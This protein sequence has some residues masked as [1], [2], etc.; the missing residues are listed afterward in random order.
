MPEKYTKRTYKHRKH[1]E[2]P[3]PEP[4]GEITRVR[5]DEQRPL[6]VPYRLFVENLYFVTKDGLLDSVH[7]KA[8]SWVINKISA[9]EEFDMELTDE[10]ALRLRVE[11]KCPHRL[12]TIDIVNMYLDCGATN[13]LFV[14]SDE[15]E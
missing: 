14:V 4:E 11:E 12:A 13:Q 2:Q 10:K 9:E 1:C 5:R 15:R 3:E 8:M 6:S 7:S